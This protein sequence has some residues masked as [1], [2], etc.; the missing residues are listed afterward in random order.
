GLEEEEIALGRPQL[1]V[2][3]KTF[4]R[5]KDRACASAFGLAEQPA[6]HRELAEQAELRIQR[7]VAVSGHLAL[8]PG[9]LLVQLAQRA[10]G[11]VPLSRGQRGAIGFEEVDKLAEVLQER[12]R[13]GLGDSQQLAHGSLLVNGL[14]AEAAPGLG[15]AGAVALKV[16]GG[17][18]M[19][20][21]MRRRR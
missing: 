14:G 18:W 19:K 17:P 6:G 21:S 11:Q 12:R 8:R 3:R 2:L 10:A 13:L 5:L 20:P 15:L 7:L 16:R 9:D 4:G 1:A